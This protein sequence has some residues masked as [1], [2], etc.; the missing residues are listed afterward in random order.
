[1]PKQHT[2]S[3]NKTYFNLPLFKQQFLFELSTWLQS[4]VPC[5]YLAETIYSDIPKSKKVGVAVISA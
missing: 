1:M 3:C 2:I 4:R 5:V